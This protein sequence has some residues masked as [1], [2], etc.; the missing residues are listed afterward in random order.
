MSRFDALSQ[1]YRMPAE[2][3]TQQ[4][5]YLG[6]PVLENREELWASHYAQVC[7][8]FALVARTIARFQRCIV[9]AH[10][11]QAAHAQALCGNT[12]TV[13][14]V[15][16][17]DNW[18]RDCGPI[19]LQGAQGQLG[20]AVFRF[21][22]W[23]EKYQPYDGCQQLGQDIARHAGAR[24]FNSEMVL[25]GGSFYVDGQG[26][27]LTTESCLL[28]P[29]RNPHMS[30]PEIENELKRMLGVTQI[31]WLP[32]NPDEV[33][34]NGHIDGIASFI[35]PGR[36][37]LQSAKQDQGDYFKIMQENRRAL[38]LA[39]DSRGRR[40][41]LLELPSPIVSK[42]FGSER[43]CDCYANYILVNGAVIAT[44][45]GVAED[46]AAH[47]AFSLAFPGRQVKLLPVPTI[48]IGGGS[49]HCS[50]QQQP[51]TTGQLPANI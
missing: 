3:E 32:G 13:L 41:E 38:E 48:S 18:V 27:L 12:V 8:E 35:A 45:F 42:R 24:L 31:I 17:E 40:F 21:N 50:T 23:G 7:A 16:A 4:A 10:H 22:A 29:N 25:E 37:L 51:A 15:A 6:W 20:A 14:P 2:W 11:S 34:T 43:Y 49:L 26:S 28:H 9:T 36:I 47:K 46:E 19:F 39:H 33:E 5:S 1:G 30:R 44:A